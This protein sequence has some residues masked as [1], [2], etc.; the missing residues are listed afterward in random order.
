MK[1]WRAL[2]SRGGIIGLAL[3]A[4]AAL[5]LALAAWFTWRAA[6]A[7]EIVQAVQSE[8][9]PDPPE[10]VTIPAGNNLN[11]FLLGLLVFGLLLVVL[12]LAYQTRRFFALR[13]SLDRN[14]VTI[15]TG[16]RRQVIP[17][18]NI[19]HVLPARTVLGQTAPKKDEPAAPPPP[20]S[21]SP[22]ASD[23]P[24]RAYPRTRT[25]STLEENALEAEP[26][27]KEA[28]VIEAEVKET[29]VA[30]SEPANPSY[31]LT[32]T[33]AAD[34]SLDHLEDIDVI[35]AD[36]V[37]IQDPLAGDTVASPVATPSETLKPEDMRAIAVNF[38]NG[39]QDSGP[40]STAEPERPAEEV[41]TTT[42][43]LQVKKR[44]FSS[45]PGFYTH[46]AQL[47][48][49]GPVQFYATQPL[50][51]CL[52]VRTDTLT[53][54]ISPR[55]QQQFIS[56]YKL[57][58][59]LG[60][61][62]PVQETVLKGKFLSHPLWHDR[63]GRTLIALAVIFNLLLYI[64][65][66]ARFNDVSPILRIHFNKFGQVDRTGERGE[67]LLLPF[68]GLLALAGNTLLGAFV[69]LRERIPAYLLYASAI[70]IQALTAIAVVV[71]LLVS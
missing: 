65:L 60:A 33:A 10:L 34:S 28:E 47:P 1:D 17:L 25:M 50:A 20:P 43:S 13:Y 41:V 67:L 4:G 11:T 69:H 38:D 61:I 70:L 54:A 6:T 45:W 18:A 71:I 53:Y 62:E 42:A 32:Q 56:E 7:T 21:S 35:Q 23:T 48:V 30:Q 22:P 64:F 29:E 46:Q 2:P 57:R 24:A 49:L 37:E 55:D 68:I 15:T 12:Y 27:L 44:P 16:D 36:F 8:D 52:L 9:S 39:E 26:D 59:R 3:T 19:R 51:D 5:L 40:Q 14:A 31:Q 66:L 58:R 63:L